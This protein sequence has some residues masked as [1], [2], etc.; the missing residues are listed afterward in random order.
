MNS[1]IELPECVKM[2]HRIQEK[3]LAET[4]H[5]TEEQRQH[6]SLEIINANPILGPIYREAIAAGRVITPVPRAA[7]AAEAPTPYGTTS[8]PASE[9]Y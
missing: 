3:I 7:S 1:Q 4:A 6:H 5:M 8:P 2:K 9:M